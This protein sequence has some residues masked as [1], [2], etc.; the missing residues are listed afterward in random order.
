MN[1]LSYKLIDIKMFLEHTSLPF[2]DKL[3]DSIQ[4]REQQGGNAQI[5]PEDAEQ[6]RQAQVGAAAQNPKADAMINQMMARSGQ[7]FK[8]EAEV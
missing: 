1:M 8:G 2:A 3:L 5:D 7:E 4:K 6:L